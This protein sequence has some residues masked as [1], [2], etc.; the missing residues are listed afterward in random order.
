MV[1]A[2]PTPTTHSPAFPGKRSADRGSNGFQSAGAQAETRC[3]VLAAVRAERWNGSP[4][5]GGEG[6]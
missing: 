4:R 5:G 1:L 3:A 6:A 2:A